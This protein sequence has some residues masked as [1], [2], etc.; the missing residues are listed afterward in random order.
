MSRNATLAAALV[1]L[2]AGAAFAQVP[3]KPDSSKAPKAAT[4]AAG[5]R[6]RAV[7]RGQ[8]SQVDTDKSAKSKTAP[9]SV[10]K[11][12][13]KQTDVG[14]TGVKTGVKTGP[15]TGS[16]GAGKKPDST[17]KKP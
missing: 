12:A 8:N 11:G 4:T 6:R 14:K 7:P 10:T 3:S 15:K 1:L 5:G 13:V 17:A 2:S 16:K 9:G